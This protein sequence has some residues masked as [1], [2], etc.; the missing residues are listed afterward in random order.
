M[1][2]EKKNN[3]TPK[4]IFWLL[5]ACSAAFWIFGAIIVNCFPVSIDVQTGVV[6]TFIGILATFVVISNYAQMQEMK[7]DFA[8][9][10]DEIEKNADANITEIKKYQAEFIKKQKEIENQRATLNEMKWRIVVNNVR[11]LEQ[12][13]DLNYEKSDIFIKNNLLAVLCYIDFL[14]EKS[15]V[16]MIE[17]FLTKIIQY[18]NKEKITEITDKNWYEINL[19][20]L[21]EKEIKH[22]EQLKE[23]IGKMKEKSPKESQSRYRND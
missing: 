10:V 15:S 17:S 23:L 6:L 14:D 5:I 18:I 3:F 8:A 16:K 19:D 7:R 4:N 1:C 11:V 20:F 21:S 9:K 13:A 2:E 22:A 12:C